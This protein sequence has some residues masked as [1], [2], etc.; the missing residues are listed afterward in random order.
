MPTPPDQGSPQDRQPL[1]PIRVL[2][3]RRTDA[4]AELIRE[5]REQ[6]GIYDREQPGAHE[7]EQRGA[8]ERE[9]NRAYEAVALAKTPPPAEEETQELPPVAPVRRPAPRQ[10]RRDR[11]RH[12]RRTAVIGAV[13]AA[14]VVGFGC[15]FLL[16]GRSDTSAA[17]PAAPPAPTSAAP[18][19]AA[20]PSAAP[21][22]SAPSGAIDPDGAGTLR[23]G[24]DGPEV[25]DLQQR[26]LRIPDVYTGGSTSG[27]YDATL[28]EAVARFQLWYGIR[29]DETGVYGDDTRRDLESR[30]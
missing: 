27:R 2:R 13:V 25:T 15:A 10:A 17:S 20:P 14:A 24:A 9:W 3:P 11:P 30:T 8:D 4:L 22:P 5:Y 1:E 26:L 18:P 29:G 21:T 23:E 19:S 12:L 7:R 28:T 16:P 6:N